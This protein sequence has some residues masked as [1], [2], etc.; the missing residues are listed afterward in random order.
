MKRSNKTSPE[1]AKT[2]IFCVPLVSAKPKEK[3]KRP[4]IWFKIPKIDIPKVQNKVT[5]LNE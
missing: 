4:K 5:R 3:N 2:R 1:P